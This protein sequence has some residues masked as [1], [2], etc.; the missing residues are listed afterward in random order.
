MGNTNK[1]C[2]AVHTQPTDA[3]SLRISRALLTGVD[4]FSALLVLF[5]ALTLF[6]PNGASALTAPIQF[7]ASSYTFDEN[8][9][10]VT[11]DVQKPT[12]IQDAATVDFT[13]TNGSAVAGTDFIIGIVVFT[14]LPVDG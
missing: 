5:A 12:Q 14:T 10:T 11:I 6:W 1:A 7:G 3:R 4:P 9:G 2:R 13:V 8:A